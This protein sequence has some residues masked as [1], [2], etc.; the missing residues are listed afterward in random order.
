MSISEEEASISPNAP[1]KYLNIYEN[2][3]TIKLQDEP[4]Y[5]TV[6]ELEDE[7]QYETVLEIKSV[8]KRD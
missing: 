8:E 4:C 6:T 3:Y 2:N 1:D 5:E 7:P